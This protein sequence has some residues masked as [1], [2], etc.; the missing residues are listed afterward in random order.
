MSSTR[1][2][3]DTPREVFGL[4]VTALVEMAIFFTIALLLDR[5]A[6]DGDRFREVAPHP[7]WA[8]VVLISLQYG[9]NE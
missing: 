4:R 7:F 8:A 5:Y 3:D 9:T 6:F 1:V 2:E